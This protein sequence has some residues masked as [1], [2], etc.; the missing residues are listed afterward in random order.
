[1]LPLQRERSSAGDLRS[2]VVSVATKTSLRYS[3]VAGNVRRDIGASY[4]G[5]SFSLT[6]PHAMY[7]VRAIDKYSISSP[8]KTEI[9]VVTAHNGNV[10]CTAVRTH[11]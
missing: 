2:P 5:V 9:R 11:T 4:T 7:Q 10:V 3:Y 1:M 6:V 8:N